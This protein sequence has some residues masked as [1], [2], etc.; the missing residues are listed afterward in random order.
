MTW[1]YLP[2]SVFSAELVGSILQPNGQ[3]LEPSAMSNGTRTARKTSLAESGATNSTMLQSM[4]MF[5]PSMANH[6]GERWISFLED[7]LVSPPL[8]EE[9]G[10]GQ[11]IKEI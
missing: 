1:V 9:N 5:A 11:E 2:G 3:G 4:T 7:S 10:G 8:K 6:G